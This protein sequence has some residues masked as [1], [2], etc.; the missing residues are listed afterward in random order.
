MPEL[1]GV[2][3]AQESALETVVATLTTH[4]RDL[5]AANERQVQRVRQLEGAQSEMRSAMAE[6]QRAALTS[7]AEAAAL[8][9]SQRRVEQELVKVQAESFSA[10]ERAVESLNGGTIQRIETYVDERLAKIG[11]TTPEQSPGPPEEAIRSQLELLDKKFDYLSRV[12]METKDLTRKV[13]KQDQTIDGM[14]IGLEMLSKSI[15]ADEGNSDG[16]DDDD[17]EYGDA[18]DSDSDMSDAQLPVNEIFGPR[19]AP[20]P[21]HISLSLDRLRQPPR[22]DMESVPSP[23]L[24]D[25]NV[26][27]MAAPHAQ[28]KRLAQRRSL[29]LD[30]RHALEIKEAQR[31]ALTSRGGSPVRRVTSPQAIQP[32]AEAPAL[33]E[34]SPHHS[35]RED[36]LD[37][38]DSPTVVADQLESYR[39]VIESQRNSSEDDSGAPEVT[40]IDVTTMPETGDVDNADQPIGKDQHEQEKDKTET[41]PAP[42]SLNRE[43]EKQSQVSP[44]AEEPESPTLPDTAISEQQGGERDAP[45]PTTAR[46]SVIPEEEEHSENDTDSDRPVDIP[47]A[48]KQRTLSHQKQ[49]EES[50]ALFHPTSTSSSASS[51]SRAGYPNSSRPSLIPSASAVF[52]SR[53]QERNARRQTMLIRKESGMH[54]ERRETTARAPLS[55]NDKKETWRRIFAKLISCAACTCPMARA[56]RSHCSE[57][58]TPRLV[59]ACGDWKRQPSTWRRRSSCSRRISR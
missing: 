51:T 18:N 37:V 24:L 58:K 10:L 59:R 9:E 19:S 36:G 23:R 21:A 43:H 2:L 22:D 52:R 40:P 27:N 1:A 48:Y 6:L 32:I 13:E 57:S 11:T 26:R 35:S 49:L 45:V 3:A 7:Q 15:G 31:N 28:I 12:K 8:A 5:L 55:D 4:V 30:V 44:I 50:V 20:K 34:G 54:T 56:Q 33:H 42:E 17:D 46:S 29:T 39:A 16:D 41:S 53:R 38:Q 14:K 25:E 47:V